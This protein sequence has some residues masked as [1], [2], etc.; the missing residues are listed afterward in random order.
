MGPKGPESQGLLLA[1]Q[2]GVG[3]GR[4]HHLKHPV[5]GF[6]GL[7]HGGG[8]PAVLVLLWGCPNNIVLQIRFAFP[9]ECES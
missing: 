4:D 8:A 1:T 7:N 9:T 5:C 3:G 2:Q 6:P